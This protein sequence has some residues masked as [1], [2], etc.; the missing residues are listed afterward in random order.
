MYISINWIK[1]YVDLKNVNIENLINQFTLSCAEVEEIIYKGRDV[2]GVVTAKIAKVEPHPNS[3]K[4]SLLT[5]DADKNYSVVC[6]APNVREGMIVPFAKVGATLPGITIGEAIVA[7]VKSEGMCCSAKELGISDDHSGL[8][9]CEENSPI[10]V[11][12]KT[13]LDIDDIVFEVDNKSLTNRPD[14]WGHYGIAREIAALANKE[15]KPLF[16]SDEKGRGDKLKISVESDKC[17]RYTG[18]TI[19]NITTKFSPINMQIRLF[20]CGMRSINFLTDLTNYIMLELGQPMHAFDNEKV[21]QIEVIKL[22]KSAQFIT[23]DDTEHT[24]NL[25]TTMIASNGELVAIAGVMGGSISGIADNTTS[26]LLESANFDAYDVRRT[27]TA[28]GFRTESSSR[29]EKSL[30]PEMTMVAVKRFIALVK[31]FDA[32][33][34]LSSVITDIYTYQFPKISIDITKSFIDKYV[35]QSIDEKQIIDILTSLE[36]KVLVLGPGVYK[37]SVPSFRATKDVSGKADLVEEITRIFGYDNIV[38][39]TTLQPLHSVKLDEVVDKEYAVKF[40][41]SQRYNFSETHSYI[42]YDCDTNKD[43]GLVAPSVINIVNSIQKDN[44]QI[45]ASIT[46]MQLK[47]AV[48]NKN[49]YSKFGIFEVGRVVK[50]L[51]AKGMAV[52]EKELNIFAFSKEEKDTLLLDIKNM[53]QYVFDVELKKDISFKRAYPKN[54]W[55]SP[56][57]FYEVYSS[58]KLIG[59]IG[60]IHPL[61][62]KRIDAKAHASVAEIDFNAVLN[63]PSKKTVFAKISKFPS[64]EF[65]FNFTLAKTMTYAEVEAIAKSISTHLKFSVSLVDIYDEEASE[66][67]NYTINFKLWRDDATI[68]TEELEGFHK[69]VISQFKEHNIH[70]KN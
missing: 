18:V 16:V 19:D 60:N 44:N 58:D 3:K 66:N 8:F 32:G 50:K 41:L 42:W 40:A 46:P 9:E 61:I 11:D 37:V 48:E 14:L 7:G 70:L 30:D 2:K 5:V 1:D 49:Y 62:L 29:Y 53:V 64:S 21:Q 54:N 38:P 26:V 52:E 17:F 45:R 25:G 4:L 63:L 43:L 31:N 68:K 28:L 13:L 36:F 34:K 23:L 35:G 51:D 39:K 69:Q 57:N 65:D 33:A 15:L 12:I 47:H 6:G 24:L 20:Y 10:G 27:A 67:K 22:K 56:A 59:V 55:F